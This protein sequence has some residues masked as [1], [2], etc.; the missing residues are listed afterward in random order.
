L[1]YR[2]DPGAGLW[3]GAVRRIHVSHR[4]LKTANDYL[5]HPVILDEERKGVTVIIPFLV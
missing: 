2:H 1:W 4:P 3:D 5:L